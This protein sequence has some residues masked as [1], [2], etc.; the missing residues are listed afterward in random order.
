[1][2]LPSLYCNLRHVPWNMLGRR[3]NHCIRIQT[4]IVLS[5]SKYSTTSMSPSTTTSTTWVSERVSKLCMH[6]YGTWRSRERFS[7]FSILILLTKCMRHDLHIFLNGT[8]TFIYTSF[9][10][11]L[12]VCATNQ[13]AKETKTGSQAARQPGSQAGSQAAS[14]QSFRWLLKR[15]SKKKRAR[16]FI[17]GK[18]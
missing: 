5:F 11:N 17:I 4:R 13:P 12:L 3:N 10:N 7:R 8:A 16:L 14:L 18:I 6:S 15:N 2:Y 1:M 9:K